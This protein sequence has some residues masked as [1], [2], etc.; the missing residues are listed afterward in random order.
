MRLAGHTTTYGPN[1]IMNE[2]GRLDVRSHRII[3]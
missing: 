1:G 2:V 3:A